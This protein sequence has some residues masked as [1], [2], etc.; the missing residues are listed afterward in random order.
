MGAKF[1]PQLQAAGV[2]HGEDV[3]GGA[4]D[5]CNS[6]DAHPPEQRVLSPLVAPGVEEGDKLTAEGIHPRKVRSLTQVSAVAR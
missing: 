1:G 4:T 2:V 3:H 6:H 5:G